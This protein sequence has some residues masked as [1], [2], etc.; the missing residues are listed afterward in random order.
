MHNPDHKKEPAHQPPAVRDRHPNR[1]ETKPGG[2]H[3]APK[4][5]GR[6]GKYSWGD[7]VRS[8]LEAELV[9]GRD[10]PN[11]DSENEDVQFAVVEL[12]VLSQFKEICQ[13]ALREYFASEDS[14][15]IARVLHEQGQPTWLYEF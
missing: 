10:D 8:E 6:G 15:E 4:K 2:A 11:Y 12:D 9:A 13:A 7:P 5:G 3:G 1:H 14:G